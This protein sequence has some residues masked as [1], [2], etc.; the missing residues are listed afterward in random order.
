LDV[1]KDL[2]NEFGPS[3]FRV[4]PYQRRQLVGAAVGA[5]ATGLR[6]IAEIMFMDFITVAMDEIV[7]RLL[8]C[9]IC[10]VVKSL[11]PLL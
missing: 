4:H 8:K 3:R 5:A 10:L 7:I 11:Y 9:A 1:T 2:F 6:P